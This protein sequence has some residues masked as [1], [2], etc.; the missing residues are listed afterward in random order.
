MLC[1]Q[2]IRLYNVRTETDGSLNITDRRLVSVSLTHSLEE[3]RN[4]TFLTMCGK[5]KNVCGCLIRSSSEPLKQIVIPLRYW[6]DGEVKVP[7][8][9]SVYSTFVLSDAHSL[10]FFLYFG[11]SQFSFGGFPLCC[12]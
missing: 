8:L 3:H 9:C 4:N 11:E 2:W 6:G 5:L 1:F 10:S 12:Q 7:L